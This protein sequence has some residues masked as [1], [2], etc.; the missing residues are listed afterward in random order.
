LFCSGDRFRGY[1]NVTAKA[2]IL[3]SNTIDTKGT[4]YPGA[5]SAE[6][7]TQKKADFVRIAGVPFVRQGPGTAKEVCFITIEEEK[8]NTRLIA[9]KTF[10]SNSRS[11][12]TDRRSFA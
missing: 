8:C 12:L 2:D 10:T 1:A 9:W 3:S 7:K 11:P 4:G 5:S 6:L